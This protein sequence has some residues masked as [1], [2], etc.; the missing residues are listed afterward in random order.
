MAGKPEDRPMVQREL[1][2]R[3]DDGE[4]L[5]DTDMSLIDNGGSVAVTV[6]S[7]ARKIHGFTLGD[8]ANIEIYADGI[9]ISPGGGVDE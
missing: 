4:P 9:W 1:A 5:Y 2:N 7:M 3:A 6:P 8:G